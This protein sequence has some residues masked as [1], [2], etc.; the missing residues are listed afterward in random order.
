MP[1]TRWP[2]R[3][4]PRCGWNRSWADTTLRVGL[5]HWA[6]LQLELPIYQSNRDTDLASRHT[7]WACP[8]GFNRTADRAIHLAKP[9]PCAH[10]RPVKTP[11]HASPRSIRHAG[12]PGDLDAGAHRPDPQA[13]A[14]LAGAGAH[15]AGNA[16]G[17][18]RV[19][20]LAPALG[21]PGTPA[22]L[23]ITDDT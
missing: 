23:S 1:I 16:D 4:R 17:T 21:A 14:L 7:L 18:G 6:E 10:A 3:A 15:R 20:R 9:P 8:A 5:V 2:A 11:P 12:G 13:M 19:A 22:V